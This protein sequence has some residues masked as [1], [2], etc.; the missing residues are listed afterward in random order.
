[1]EAVVG[2]QRAHGVSGRQ[3]LYHLGQDG[4][5]RPGAVVV[6]ERERVEDGGHAGG[7]HLA[8]VR[9]DCS[10]DGRPPNPRPRKEV[11]LDIVSMQI[12]KAGNEEI[13]FA[14]D[15]AGRPA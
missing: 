11:S 7:D 5:A 15:D 12:D 2:S 9:E 13:A 14:I 6:T 1:M 10:H 8:V 4:P 3:R